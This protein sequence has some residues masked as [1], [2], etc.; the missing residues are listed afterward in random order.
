MGTAIIIYIVSI[1]MCKIIIQ[2]GRRI[3]Y[4]IFI[5]PLKV[6]YGK[7][8]QYSARPTRQERNSGNCSGFGL[9]CWS[10]ALAGRQVGLWFAA[11]LGNVLIALWLG[12]NLTSPFDAFTQFFAI[13][14]WLV[15]IACA[16]LLWEWAAQRAV[17][18][19]AQSWLRARWLPGCFFLIW[20]S[21]R[22]AT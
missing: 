2:I 4:M 22:H 17:R 21:E 3:I 7:C 5:S 8:R 16:I 20:P 12:R 19:D 18:K 13:P 6:F 14:E 10:L 11:W 15:A 1:F 9:C